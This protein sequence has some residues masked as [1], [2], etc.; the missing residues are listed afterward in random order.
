MMSGKDGKRKQWEV[1]FTVG[2]KRKYVNIAYLLYMWCAE[3][4]TSEHI[5]TGRKMEGIGD[6]GESNEEHVGMLEIKSE[7]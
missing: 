5:G 1:I 6:G 7:R 4:Y 2:R 3:L